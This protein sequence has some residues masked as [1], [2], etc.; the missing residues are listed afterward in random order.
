MTWRAFRSWPCS[1]RGSSDPL[2]QGPSTVTLSF[3]LGSLLG[4]AVQVDPV[5]KPC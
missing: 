1:T 2:H 4:K 3:V 5:W